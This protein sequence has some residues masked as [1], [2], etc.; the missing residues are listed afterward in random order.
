MAISTQSSQPASSNG[1]LK[2]AKIIVTVCALITTIG[3]YLADYNETHL[4]NP[5]WPPHA[6]FHDAQ[7]MLLSFFLCVF[8]LY[9]AWRRD[10]T[11]SHLHTALLVASF[12]WFSNLGSILFPGTAF[13]DPERA[14]EGLIFG[15]PGAAVHGTM[16]LMLI[17][18]AYL[19]SR[20]GRRKALKSIGQSLTSH[21]AQAGLES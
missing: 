13:A 5:K 10:S 8:V 12:Y 14:G 20:A 16:Q 21:A 17:G 9:Y 3:A 1:E 7:T 19:L 15:L 11:T 18:I 2:T 4:F 6:K